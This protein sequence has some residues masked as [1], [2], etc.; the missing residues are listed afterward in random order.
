M[1]STPSHAFFKE[2][3]E[4]ASPKSHKSQAVQNQST[5]CNRYDKF[6]LKSQAFMSVT[7]NTP[8]VPNGALFWV[9]EWQE[10]NEVVVIHLT[11]TAHVAGLCMHLYCF[12]Y[13]MRGDS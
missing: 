12:L 1:G 10:W 9:H 4:A 2:V 11:M 8:P 7:K 5:S 6:A 13:G 3:I